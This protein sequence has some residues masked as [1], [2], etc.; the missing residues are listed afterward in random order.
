LTGQNRARIDFGG[1]DLVSGV[2]DE[3]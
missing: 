1:G 3:E 2:A